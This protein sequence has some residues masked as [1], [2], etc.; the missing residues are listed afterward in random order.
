[1]WIYAE[2]M[3]KKRV[4]D[5]AYLCLICRKRIEHQK[6]GRARRTCSDKCRQALYRQEHG[7]DT[8]DVKRRRREVRRRRSL[9]I[10]EHRFSDEAVPVFNL[11]Q[12]RGYYECQVCG[13]GYLVERLESRTQVNRYC[14]IKCERKARRAW[15]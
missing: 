2:G 4:E 8:V 13:K 12:R 3:N 5:P 10:T 1:M 15:K 11:G 7:K 6:T 9:P 14:S